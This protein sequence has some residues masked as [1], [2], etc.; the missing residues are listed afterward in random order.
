MKPRIIF[1]ILLLMNSLQPSHCLAISPLAHD[2]APYFR[3]VNV[4]TAP[5]NLLQKTLAKCGAGSLSTLIA[6]HCYIPV[7]LAPIQLLLRHAYRP[8]VPIHVFNL[9]ALP[10]EALIAS[11]SGFFTPSVG[12]LLVG[13]LVFSIAAIVYLWRALRKK[14]KA[15]ATQKRAINLQQKKL[16]ESHDDLQW[17]LL[18][19]EKLTSEKEKLE[20]HLATSIFEPLQQTTG[21]V[22]FIENSG[23]L[24]K[25][26]F[27]YLKKLE[28]II[29]KQ[30]K[31]LKNL[32]PFELPEQGNTNLKM[33]YF[34][35]SDWFHELRS[36]FAET[37]P[38]IDYDLRSSI[39]F[40]A[41]TDLKMLT[42]M[43]ENM[44]K[45]A[46]RANNGNPMPIKVTVWQLPDSYSIAIYDQGERIPNEDITSLFIKYRSE[47]LDKHP[48]N[49]VYQKLALVKAIL[50]ILNGLIQI[51]AD[52]A[53]T[54]GNVFQITMPTQ[55]LKRQ[56]TAANKEL[57][58]DH[59]LSQQYEQI[60]GEIMAKKMFTDPDL[61]IQKVADDIGITLHELS[62]II[63]KKSGK[64]FQNFIN[65]LRVEEAIRLLSHPQYSH[66]SLLGIGF[67]AGFNAKSTFYTAFKKATG[68]T[69]REFQK[70]QKAAK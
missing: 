27:N 26:Q 70:T 42:F 18:S 56:A 64:N 66:L 9:A 36:K 62:Y 30:K 58:P 6:T 57:I 32:L 65:S 40:E 68:I 41:Q 35:F 61:N 55:Y 38:P 59:D 53:E 3:S 52:N 67:E 14:D 45:N 50:D 21:L 48:F 4:N 47:D 1:I 16:E 24:N 51:N 60:V 69:P 13:W 11:E 28:N 29:F 39:R 12:Y 46:L 37:E 2:D 33:E 54:N 31:N 5:E 10:Y 17:L 49:K 25:E 19:H 44:I 63:N 7:Y 23:T 8:Q 15:I 22:H 20:D 34:L 43:V